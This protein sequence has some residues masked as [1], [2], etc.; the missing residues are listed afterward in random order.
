MKERRVLPSS[1]QIATLAA[2][3][4]ISSDASDF[5]PSSHTARRGVIRVAVSRPF[6]KYACRP[7]TRF[8]SGIRCPVLGLE[9]FVVSSPHVRRFLLFFQD[10]RGLQENPDPRRW[11]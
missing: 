5:I 8:S 1:S 6:Q 11:I 7:T 9:Q 3:M 4:R 10:L 2:S